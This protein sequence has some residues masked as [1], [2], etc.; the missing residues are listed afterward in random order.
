MRLRYTWSLRGRREHLLGIGLEVT[1]I[2]PAAGKSLR[3]AMP[4][5]IPGHYVIQ[6]NA[7]HVSAL[8]AR[9]GTKQLALRSLDKQ[10][11]EVE[12]GG[13]RAV[14]LRYDLYAHTL[15][16]AASWLGEDQC[17]VNGG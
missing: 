1:G 10:T 2:A 15:A 16:S 7:R 14:T 3:V 9:A 13:A 8:E 5:W 4:A 12:H 17:Q 11:W 6:D